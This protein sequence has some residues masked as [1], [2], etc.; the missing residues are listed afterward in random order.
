MVTDGGYS[1][2]QVMKFAGHRNPKTLDG[3]YLD[4]MSNIDGTAVFLGLKPRRDIT[5]D[6]RSASIGRNPGLKHSLLAKI[7]EELE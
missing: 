7:V 2:G 6:F 3:H 1:L 4:D 5:E